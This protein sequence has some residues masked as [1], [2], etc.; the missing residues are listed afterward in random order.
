MPKHSITIELSMEAAQEVSATIKKKVRD[1]DW[2]LTNKP[3]AN[4]EE[5]AKL[6]NRAKILQQTATMIDKLIQPDSKV[7]VIPIRKR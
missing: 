5:V 6:D 3:P 7:V 4:H 1:I 2:V